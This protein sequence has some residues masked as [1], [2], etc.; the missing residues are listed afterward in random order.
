MRSA[1]VISDQ[2]RTGLDILTHGDFHLDED[3]AGRAV[4]HHYP[5]P[6]VGW[7]YLKATICSRRS[8]N[9]APGCIIRR[10][11]C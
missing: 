7:V 6:A 9:C 11:R 3:M 8:H 1:V 10:G 4:W 2:E 5:T